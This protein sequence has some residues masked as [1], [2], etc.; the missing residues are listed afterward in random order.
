[1]NSTSNDNE[2]GTLKG[3]KAVVIGGSRGVGEAM[4]GAFGERGA[5]VTAVARNAESLRALENRV[6]GLRT[7]AGDA[8]DET[9][10]RDLFAETSPDI[11]VLAAGATPRMA[12]ITEFNWTSF[13]DVW[14]TDVKAALLVAQNALTKPLTAGSSVIFLSSGAAIEGSPLS[15]GYAGAKWMEWKLADYAQ[16]FSDARKLGV[17]FQAILPRPIVGT[18]I[19]I[20][21]ANAYAPNAGI[22]PEAFMER[23]GVTTEQVSAAI[24]HVLEAND[25]SDTIGFVVDRGGVT[26]L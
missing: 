9:F 6:S 16:K 17:R 25:A 20:G 21:A 14:N 13:S 7:I 18:T 22:T 19:G 23:I 15:G 2:T 1:M 4:V 5:L 11:V 8:T 10:I 3:K 24:L 26:P 12:P